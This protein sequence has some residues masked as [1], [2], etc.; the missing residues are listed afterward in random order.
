[1]PS[2]VPEKHFNPFP[3]ER[4]WQKRWDL[5]VPVIRSS[6]SP[7]RVKAQLFSAIHE[8]ILFR[9][10]LMRGA[11]TPSRAEFLNIN[12][13]SAAGHSGVSKGFGVLLIPL[14]K[15]PG[16]ITAFS[17]IHEEY[18]SDVLRFSMVSHFANIP[19]YCRLKG[20]AALLRKLWHAFRYSTI[21]L[22]GDEP[23]MP[24]LENAT[25]VDRWFLNRLNTVTARIN[26]FLDR[27][28]LSAASAHLEKLIRN[29][30]CGWYL[31][32]IRG[33]LERSGTRRCLRYAMLHLSHLIHP[34][35]PHISEEIHSRLSPHGPPSLLLL[36]YPEFRSEL[37]FPGPTREV[38]ALCELIRS[39]RS[40]GRIA[41]QEILHASEI[42]L[43]GSGRPDRQWLISNQDYYLRLTGAGSLEL[44]DVPPEAGFS[45]E[46]GGWVVWIAVKDP[47][48]RRRIVR[49][50][51][52]RNEEMVQR[53]RRMHRKLNDRKFLD[54]ISNETGL[55]WKR[56][57]QTLIRLQEDTIQILASLE[58][59]NLK[60]KKLD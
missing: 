53:I 34:F 32:L 16:D 48:M 25:D 42:I 39:T 33:D 12:T 29:D 22:K 59:Q 2:P 13:A 51:R 31:E 5:I 27:G 7:P 17:G 23:S 28:I 10:R 9:Y 20:S 56:R 21:H 8:D 40:A 58:R 47:V 43:L 44:R 11:D 54:T 36:P 60:G 3:M 14:D 4:S 26:D 15:T 19:S 24:D 35:M 52:S 1:M 57:L 45:G 41:P 50:L 46:A 38:D 30:F 37:V 6:T 55:R 49:R 18:G